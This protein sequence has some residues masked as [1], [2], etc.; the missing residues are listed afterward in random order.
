MCKQDK[1][2][3]SG[4]CALYTLFEVSICNYWLEFFK[5]NYV[6]WFE[7]NHNRGSS[8]ADADAEAEAAAAAAA[9]RSLW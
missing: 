4:N 6:F 2:K 5:V 1:M 9:I 3:L 7:N 8:V